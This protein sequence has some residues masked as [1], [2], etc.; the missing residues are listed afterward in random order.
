MRN[1]GKKEKMKGTEKNNEG[2][3]TMTLVKFNPNTDL[4]RLQR[5]M[6][7]AFD[8]FFGDSE[9]ENGS[10]Q[11]D[12]MPAVDIS[13]T[14]NEIVI[15]A[16]VP[17]MNK[18]DIKVVVHDNTLTLKGERK[19]ETKEEKTNYY[20]MERTCGSFYRS[21]S[22]PSMVDAGKIK[23]NYVNGVLEIALPKVEEAKPKEIAI[24]VS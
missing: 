5:S 3:S 8:K 22:L 9:W 19:Y 14:E 13:E 12:W 23:A 16:D 4:F 18:E 20:R 15:K 21:F 7:R 24:N 10:T 17:G 11:C 6:N 2:G 1:G